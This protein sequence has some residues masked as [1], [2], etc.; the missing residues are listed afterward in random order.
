MNYSSFVIFSALTFTALTIYLTAYLLSAVKDIHTKRDAY[1]F[2]ITN[3]ITVFTFCV[4]VDHITNPTSNFVTKI[5]TG[6]ITSIFVIANLLIGR[7]LSRA[8]VEWRALQASS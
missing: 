3:A 8:I 6:S 4:V 2:R 1:E 7:R 5:A